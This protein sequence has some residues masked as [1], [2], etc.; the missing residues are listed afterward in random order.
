MPTLA[1]E[2]LSAEFRRCLTAVGF[3]A[4]A[5]VELA[6]IFL[7]NTLAG[8]PSH[9]VNRFPRFIAQ[10]R[11]GHVDPTAQPERGLSLGALERWSGN[12]GAGPLAARR[13]MTRATELAGTHGVGVVALANTN[14]WMR[15]GT[16]AHEA[17]ERGFFAICWTNTIALMPP[18]GAVTPTIGNNPLVVAVPGE[19]VTLVD[20][21]MSLYSYGALERQR[22]AGRQ[23]EADGG[24]DL[25][26]HLTRD[27]AAIEASRRLLPAGL[28]KG[29]SLAIVLDMAAALM[30]GG[31]ATVAITEDRPEESLISQVFLAVDLGRLVDSAERD[32]TLARIRDHITGSTPVD[33]ARPVRL[34]GHELAERIARQRRDGIEVDDAIWARIRAL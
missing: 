33:P 1:P 5:A 21:A 34:P 13:M 27:P 22:L 15:G 11:A 10:V 30:S 9:G 2:T 7:D 6:G 25:D 19:P 26:G 24:Y 4:A 23:L 14:H 12:G 20:M 29:S 8:V 28:W 31:L 16:F 18:W 17:A 3:D 32:A